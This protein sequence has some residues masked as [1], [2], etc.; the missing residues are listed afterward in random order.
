VDIWGNE[1]LPIKAE[2]VNISDTPQDENNM[3]KPFVLQGVYPNPFNPTTHIK[4]SLTEA[5]KVDVEVYDLR[6]HRVADLV[7]KTMAK[8]THSIP[9]APRD[10]PS[11]TYF[12]RISAGGQVETTKM[13]LLK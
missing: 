7:H 1:S 9:F 13:L 6:G 12:A 3:A 8:G 10:L 4:F 5:Q 11:G 2:W